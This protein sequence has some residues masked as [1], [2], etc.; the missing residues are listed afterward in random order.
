MADPLQIDI[1]TIFPGML[2]GFLGESMLRRAVQKG[3]VAFR[4]INLR[5][6]AEGPHRMTDDRPYGGGPG[7][8]MKPEPI[9]RA[10]DALH[11][12]DSHLVLT[13]PQ[14]RRFTQAVAQ[15][16][17]GKRHLIFLCGHYEGIDERV[18]EGLQPDEISIGDYILTHGV[19]AAAVVIDAVVRLLPGVLGH[20]AATEE[21][22]F[23]A[24]GLEYPQYTRP[25]VF[26]G[27]KVPS[28]LVSGNHADIARWRREQALRRT[29]ERRPDLLGAEGTPEE[30]AP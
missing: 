21:E 20:A 10:V 7:M 24:G 28:V 6:F 16:L 12:P 22:S 8:L 1:V 30:K 25:P 15:E 29:R 9:F 19:L 14:G 4:A 5:D 11:R 2:D 23:S 3:R 18:R 17:A 13:T 26:R 27:W